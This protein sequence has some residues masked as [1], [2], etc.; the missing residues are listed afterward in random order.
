MEWRES[1]AMYFAFPTPMTLL[2]DSCKAF[3]STQGRGE[4][5]VVNFLSTYPPCREKKTH[6]CRIYFKLLH[7]N[8]VNVPLSLPLFDQGLRCHTGGTEDLG[9]QLQ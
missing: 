6:T 9:S 7:N 5:S 1:C 4:H 8:T 2:C 3:S